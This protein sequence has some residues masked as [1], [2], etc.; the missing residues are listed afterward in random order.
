MSMSARALGGVTTGAG[1]RRFEVYLEFATKSAAVATYHNLAA[2]GVHPTAPSASGGSYWVGF[3]YRGRIALD[4]G[5]EFDLWRHGSLLKDAGWASTVG[6]VLDCSG[7]GMAVQL[8]YDDPTHA[9][10]ANDHLLKTTPTTMDPP[11]PPMDTNLDVDVRFEWPERV[12]FNSSVMR[13]GDKQIA[14]DDN[15]PSLAGI[16]LPERLSFVCQK[17]GPG[18]LSGPPRRR[19]RKAR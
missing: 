4:G 12:V 19:R 10:D 8:R 6:A 14:W 5:L 16:P 9:T 18:S 3:G 11:N 1:Q 13:L 7:G 2:L 17:P 15:D